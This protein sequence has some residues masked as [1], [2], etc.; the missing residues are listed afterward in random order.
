MRNKFLYIAALLLLSVFAHGQATVAPATIPHIQFFDSNGNPLNGGK[1]FTYIAGTTTP[2]SSYTDSTGSV[3]NTNPIILNSAGFADIWLDG[4][5]LYKIVAQNSAGVQQW[6]VDNI[7]GSLRNSRF[8]ASDGSAGSPSY[9][10]ASEPTSGA[11]RASAGNIAFSILGTKELNL[12]ATALSPGA[13]GGSDLGTS[14]LPFLNLWIGNAATNNAKLTGT[15]TAARVF[16]LPDIASDTFMF[17]NATQ[18]ISNKTWVDPSD[19]TK[20]LNFSI[21]GNTTGIT[22]TIATN[23]TTNKTFTLPNTNGIAATVN[24]A[25]SWSAALSTPAAPT[26]TPTCSGTCASTWGY[27]IIAIDPNG[28]QSSASSAQTT[29]LQSNTLDGSHFNVI[30][31]AAV[32]GAASYQIYR[33]TVAVSPAT[34]GVI[35]SVTT[36]ATLT[37]TDSGGA[38]DASTAPTANATGYQN[39]MFLNAPQLVNSFFNTNIGQGTAFKFQN[40]STGPPCSTAAAAGATCTNAYT[41]T[42]PF[43]DSN[44]IMGCTGIGQGNTAA[45]PTVEVITASGF[46]VR[47][48]AITAAV[49]SFASYNCWAWHP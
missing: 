10:F 26:V 14:A 4:T 16:T 3:L 41:W 32:A 19:A 22:G 38:G 8:F 6:S 25:Q 5:K 36:G 49:G 27:K 21:S 48:T 12:S 11:Y 29:A 24:N 33:S 44:Y 15:F 37:F 34:L 31:W 1:L 18:N 7:A 47:V 40:F 43:A 28:A 20:K 35:G 13:A 39:G 23:Y 45:G 9:T 30:T 2:Q 42:S 46:T 17:L